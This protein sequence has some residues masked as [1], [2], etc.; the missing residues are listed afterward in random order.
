MSQ[1]HKNLFFFYRGA[2]P[3]TAKTEFVFERQLE[4]NAT[5]ALIYVLEHADR[6]AV[7]LPFLQRVIRVRHAASRIQEVQFAL[8][9]VDIKRPTVR[10]RIAMSIAP[11]G[12]LRPGRAGKPLSGRPDAWIWC[13][14]QFAVL[15]ETKVSGHAGRDQIRRHIDGAEGWKRRTVRW[16][17]C[18]WSEVYSFFQSLHQRASDLE[19]VTRLLIDEFVR[20]IRMLGLASNVTFELDDFGYF[21]LRTED[22][23]AT[24]RALLKRKLEQ[25]TN[26][27]VRSRG[28]RGAVRRYAGN[29]GRHAEVS[30]G[31]LRRT[32]EDYW[33][34]IGP[35]ERRDRCHLTVR[36]TQEGL[37]LEVFSPHKSFTRRLLRKI[38][39]RPEQFLAALKSMKHKEPYA[40]RLREAYYSSPDSFYRGQRIRSK[41]DYLQVHPGQLTRGNLETLILQPVRERLQRR[42]LRPEVFLVRSFRLN[43]LV[44]KSD[45][46]ELVSK[47]AE[48]MLNYFT[49]ALHL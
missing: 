25:F 35:K 48:P 20:Y 32:S 11:A 15:I 43:E 16:R 10:E 13:E 14:D 21:L 5:K 40:F 38:Q 44:G 6:R 23:N 22:R 33:I 42:D 27:L 24:Q 34:T 4:D 12:E 37:T 30:P 17:P 28:L 18:S 47:A 2:A 9:R 19:S 8:Q 41:I 39:A 3:S 29:G 36:L 1:A 26:D 46:V 45:V 49:F 7:L 31:T